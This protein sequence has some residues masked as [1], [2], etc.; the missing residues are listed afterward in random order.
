MVGLTIR[1]KQGFRVCSQPGIF[2]NYVEP[3]ETT[4]I[5]G[6]LLLVSIS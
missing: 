3:G 4:C 5:A 2:G 6:K 1:L